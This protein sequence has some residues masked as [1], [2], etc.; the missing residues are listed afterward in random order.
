MNTYESA[1]PQVNGVQFTPAEI[2]TMYE[3]AG[4]KFPVSGFVN[5]HGKAVPIVDIPSMSDYKYQY[6]ALRSR[7]QNPESYTAMGEDVEAAI[8]RLKRWL[9]EN[10]DKAKYGDTLY[11]Y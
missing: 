8:K 2:G 4:K 5:V 1:L 9:A 11:I 10:T 6:E 7:L 3:I